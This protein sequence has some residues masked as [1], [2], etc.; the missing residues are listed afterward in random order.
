MADFGSDAQG[1]PNVFRHIGRAE[2]ARGYW[3]G[4]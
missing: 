4:E 3:E 2:D 1:Q